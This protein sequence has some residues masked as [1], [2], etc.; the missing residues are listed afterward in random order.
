MK[1]GPVTENTIDYYIATKNNTVEL[2]QK[3]NFY[4]SLLPE[5]VTKRLQGSEYVIFCKDKYVC[6]SSQRKGRAVIYTIV[7]SEKWDD[8]WCYFITTGYIF[9]LAASQFHPRALKRE[10][11]ESRDFSVKM[12][13]GGRRH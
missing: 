5:R 3:K 4:D 7:I 12:L 13:D 8:R 10:L 1:R 11:F 9:Q 6:I 2:L